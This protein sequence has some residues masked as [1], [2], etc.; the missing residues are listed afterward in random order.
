MPK[1]QEPV[2]A[3]VDAAEITMEGVR[4]LS[5]FEPF[6]AGN[7]SPRFCLR[8]CEIRGITPMGGDKHLRLTFAQG[9]A[10]F[11]AV[12][13]GTSSLEFPFALGERLDLIVS[14]SLS[15]YMGREQLDIRVE[16]LRLHDLPE[17]SVLLGEQ[18]YEQLQNGEVLPERRREFAPSRDEI[19][20]VYRF[21]KRAERFPFGCESLYG[22][23]R[24]PQ[25]GFA[26]M[27]IALDVLEE[28]KLI[29]A[30]GIGFFKSYTILPVAEKVDLG[31]SS[32]LRTLSTAGEKTV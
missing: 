23:L 17:G 32:I 2:D 29:E 27:M 1:I 21:L 18:E 15:E 30:D 13:F 25:L 8:D 24:T 9:E 22:K 6:G 16:D 26:K 20:I 5:R 11:R 7:P 31:Q 4:M 28:Q 3:V 19:A 12:L 10:M 14:L